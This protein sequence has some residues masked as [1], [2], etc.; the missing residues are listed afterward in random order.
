MS[1]TTFKRGSFGQLLRSLWWLAPIIDILSHMF[2][3]LTWSSL[4]IMLKQRFWKMSTLVVVGWGTLSENMRFRLEPYQ[5]DVSNLCST[6]HA[7]GSRKLSCSKTSST[8]TTDR[9]KVPVKRIIRLGF[10]SYP[11]PLFLGPR[12]LPGEDVDSVWVLLSGHLLLKEG[13]IP[14]PLSNSLLLSSH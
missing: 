9:T 11:V 8:C 1:W 10:I 2:S 4:E 7:L 12:C 3:F 5:N 6:L 14:N 13:S